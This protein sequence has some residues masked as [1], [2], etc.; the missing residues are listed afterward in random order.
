[1]IRKR[2]DPEGRKRWIY[3]LT[4]KG[5]DAVPILLEMIV[6]GATYDPHTA[7]P[8]AFVERCKHDR[9]R[10]FAEIRARAGEN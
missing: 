1:M 6:W 10:L 8:D 3:S 5:L 9:E 7:A 2:R 4:A